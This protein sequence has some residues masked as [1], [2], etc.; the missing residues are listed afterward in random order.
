MD[1]CRSH[2][3]LGAGWPGPGSEM[4]LELSRTRARSLPW[5]A[6][7]S[8][9]AGPLMLICIAVAGCSDD[10][11]DPV[12]ADL[13]NEGF[14]SLDARG[15]G[16]EQV[17]L[18]QN[19]NDLGG[20]AGFGGSVRVT[21]AAGDVVMTA[22]DP[23][24]PAQ[25]PFFSGSPNIDIFSGDRLRV[26]GLQQLDYLRVRAG[27]TLEITGATF[28]DVSGS[29]EIAGTIVSRPIADSIDGNDLTII[30]N[31]YVNVT[32][33]I[34]VGGI[35]NFESQ[36][37]LFLTG[38]NGGEVFIYSR[39]SIL[40]LPGPHVF[41]SGII[42]AN[43][44]SADD[45]HFNNMEVRAGRGGQVFLGSG[46]TMV[47]SGKLLARGGRSTF[48]QQVPFA[49]GFFSNGGEIS[50][51]SLGDLTLGRM[52]GIVASGGSS[53]GV[54]GGDGGEVRVEA[55]G[56]TIGLAGFDVLARGGDVLY[57]ASSLGGFGG[58][59][60]FSGD[61]IDAGGGRI[62]A[63]GGGI[64]RGTAP[65]GQNVEGIGGDGGTIQMAG[66]TSMVFGADLLLRSLGGDT[67]TLS[68]DGGIGGNVMIV[69]LDETSLDV[70]DFQGAIEARGGRD[71]QST[72]AAPG[73]ICVRGAQGD[74]IDRM[75]RAND[76]PIGSCPLTILG[77][78]LDARF[79]A[80]DLD[81]D[82]T[83]IFPREVE[84][85][86]PVVLGAD[87]FR[88]RPGA[89][90]CVEVRVRGEENTTIEMYAGEQADFG[91]LDPNDYEF[92]AV[93]FDN[94]ESRVQVDLSQFTPGQY[95][96]ILL[97]GTGPF[98]ESYNLSVAY[99]TSCN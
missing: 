10:D 97:L 35:G 79:I 33:I 53:T 32:G 25:A 26:S 70:I 28:F 36:N 27:G 81:D 90:S 84:A 38:G 4:G 89:A 54:L 88:V 16:V 85:E 83:T 68:I 67:N 30:A 24:I 18:I 95:I 39:A 13:S 9:L 17:S 2:R 64:G 50:L 45:A 73:S 3:S 23:G 14:A 46:G 74:D 41:V 19:F 94:R 15:G 78:I 20:Q 82:L 56:G 37:R 99:L 48:T 87:F 61:A 42:K 44:G 77:E 63:S 55:P 29:V 93:P 91:S 59:I 96:T 69:N 80:H 71:A 22:A 40:G 72:H 51:V 66:V 58:D 75:T 7:R 49:D 6:R 62:D 31:G 65:H 43:G 98:V 57:A 11:P 76:F 8:A 1:V 92:A 5:R 60:I 52:Q 21:S 47:V 12:L 34:D 86:L